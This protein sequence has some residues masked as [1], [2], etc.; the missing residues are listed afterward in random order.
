MTAGLLVRPG[1]AGDR[2][3]LAAFVC[4]LSLD[5]SYAR[6][7]A[8]IG[9]RPSAAL[10]D[11]LLPTRPGAGSLLAFADGALVGHGLWVPSGAV[12]TAEIA[13]VVGDHHQRD[14]VGTALVEHLV[15][16]ALGQGIETIEAY[17]GSG[18]AA[19]ARM[20]ARLTPSVLVERDGPSVV[21]RF[22]S[23]ATHLAQRSVVP[24]AS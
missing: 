7:Q 18:N 16:A 13:V 11:A 10:L 6:F 19:V 20:L 14:G 9:P 21:H 4:G 5:S 23:R 17:A 8:A 1:R 2:G 15:A 24:V 22:S 3:A 12:A